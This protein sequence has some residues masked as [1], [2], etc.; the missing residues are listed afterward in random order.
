MKG[1]RAYGNNTHNRFDALRYEPDPDLAPDHD[2]EPENRTTLIPVYPKS[3]L[4]KVTSPDIPSNWSMNPYQGCEHGCSY[5]YARPTHNYWGYSA[6]L[7]FEQKILYKPN[8]AD[9]LRQSFG[10]KGWKGEKVML[11]GNTDCYQPVERKMGIT[12]QLLQVCWEYRNPVSIIT[13]NNLVRR[14]IDLLAQLAEHN[15]SAVAITVTTLNE[16]LRRTLEPRTASGQQRIET[17]RQLSAAGIPVAVMMAPVI[18][19]LNDHEIFTIAEAAAAAGATSFGYTMLRLNGELADLFGDWLE[20]NF[21]DRKER[22]LNQVKAVHNGQL[23]SHNFSERMRGK[24]NWAGIIRSQVQVARKKFY[25][26]QGWKPL[27]ESQ[28]RVPGPQLGLFD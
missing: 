25:P 3:I 20:V 6:G 2:E 17:I 10:K 24:G 5:C 19:S 16:D 22:V 1:R 9:L 13:K 23:G 11:S 14:D 15:L 27:D 8:A 12:R 26:E 28:F 21:P 4:N 18:P 7:D